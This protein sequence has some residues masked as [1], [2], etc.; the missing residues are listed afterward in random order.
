MDFALDLVRLSL[1]SITY[2]SFALCFYYNT[3]LGNIYRYHSLNILVLKVSTSYF[4]ENDELQTFSDS[5]VPLI[6]Y[7]I[8]ERN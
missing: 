8:G 3:Y 4:F 5:I 1:K 2:Q 7:L 6:R